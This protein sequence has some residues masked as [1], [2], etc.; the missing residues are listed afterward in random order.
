MFGMGFSF[1]MDRN[2]RESMGTLKVEFCERKIESSTRQFL[3]CK[4]KDKRLKTLVED[5]EAQRNTTKH[6]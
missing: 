6:N 4:N 1:E 3:H 5:N 2:E